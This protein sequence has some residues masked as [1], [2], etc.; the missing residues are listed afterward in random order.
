MNACRRSGSARPS[1]FLA[2]FHDNLRRCRAAR[3]V[4]R[5]HLSPKR[6]PAQWTR[7]RKVQRGGGSAPLRGGVA[8]VRWAA[9]TTATKS[10]SRRGGK[11]AAT[12]RVVELLPG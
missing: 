8:A 10:A 12:A 1:S 11:R 6:S 3:I 2:F 5:Q 4:S 7:R 9:Q